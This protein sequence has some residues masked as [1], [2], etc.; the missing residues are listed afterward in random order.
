VGFRKYISMRAIA[1]SQHINWL[2]TADVPL[3]YDRSEQNSGWS[4]FDM[5]LN[6]P[7]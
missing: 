3:E 5:V 1:K 6:K 7:V 2:N 4:M